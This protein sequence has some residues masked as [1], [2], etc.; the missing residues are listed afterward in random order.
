M[1]PAQPETKD[2]PK[3]P[4]KHTLDVVVYAPGETKP[5]KFS[6]DKHMLVADAAAEAAKAFGHTSGNPSLA[7]GKEVLPRDKQLVA[8]GV[9]DGDRLEL[10]DIGGGV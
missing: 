6:W 4:G 2:K 7:N 9:R 8:A 5:R 3:P 1:T 10:I